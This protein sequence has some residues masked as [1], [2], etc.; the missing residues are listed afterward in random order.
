MNTE[1]GLDALTVEVSPLDSADDGDGRRS[2]SD[3]RAEM[4][5]RR[6]SK[7]LFEVR[8]RRQGIVSDR[9]RNPRREDES[10]RA[11]YAFWRKD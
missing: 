2:G 11:W 4:E 7:G 9:R 5:R 10:P 8:A 3:R 1:T 6:G